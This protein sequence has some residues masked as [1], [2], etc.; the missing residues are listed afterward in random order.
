MKIRNLTLCVLRSQEQKFSLTSLY[1][2]AVK[3][4]I[5]RCAPCVSLCRSTGWFYL[6]VS[7][8]EAA[9]HSIDRRFFASR[10]IQVSQSGHAAYA[11]R[12]HL[13]PMTS[14]QAITPYKPLRWL[15]DRL[16]PPHP[17]AVVRHRSSGEHLD[18]RRP[19]FIF[20]LSV[21]ERRD[22]RSEAVA[23]KVS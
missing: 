11:L 23:V 18:P 15:A 7:L 8:K 14:E 6:H 5:N 13:S 1:E 4:K 12:A 20:I 2:N 16:W 22:S 9:S 19:D 21:S 10:M 3:L 17:L